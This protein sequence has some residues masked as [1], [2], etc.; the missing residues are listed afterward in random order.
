MSALSSADRERWDCWA[1]VIQCL[2]CAVMVVV[3]W[4]NLPTVQWAAGI[5][6]SNPWD[7]R[8]RFVYYLDSRPDLQADAKAKADRERQLEALSDPCH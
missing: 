2:A 6:F 7:A 4:V 8:E 5:L 1:T 3:A